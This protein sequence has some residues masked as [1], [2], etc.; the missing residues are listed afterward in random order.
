M[1]RTYCVVDIEATGGNHKNGRIIE[2]GI[3]K[4]GQGRVIAEYSTL[5]NPQQP[6]DK[7]VSKLTGISDND[8][9]NAPVFAQ[10][11][12]KIIDFLGE[13][14]FVAHNATFDY[15]YLRAELRKIGVNYVTEQLCTIDLSRQ[16]FPNEDSYSLGKL[17]Q[18]LG[19]S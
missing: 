14:I 19:L 16:I 2:I 3:V 17:C 15:A 9:A 8:L 1:E 5:V 12:P 11:A 13:S 10:V 7:Y 6:I 4:I 18:S